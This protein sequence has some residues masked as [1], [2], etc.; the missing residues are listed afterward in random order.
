[1]CGNL[2]NTYLIAKLLPSFLSQWGSHTVLTDS[3]FDY[4]PDRDQGSDSA[5]EGILTVGGGEPLPMSGTFSYRG[6]PPKSMAWFLWGREER[7]GV[8]ERMNLC[9]WE[10]RVEVVAGGKEGLWVGPGRSCVWWLTPLIPPLGRGGLRT[11][12]ATM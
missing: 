1:M 6:F 2:F 10:L 12:R 5:T 11:A 7:S 3:I 4:V 9:S 8:S